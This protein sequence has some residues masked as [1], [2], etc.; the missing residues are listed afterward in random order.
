VLHAT[1]LKHSNPFYAS[2][3]HNELVL[4]VVGAQVCSAVTTLGERP[5]RSWASL[6]AQ[7]M[8]TTGEGEPLSGRSI[9]L[10]GRF[11]FRLKQNK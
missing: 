1:N 9:S 2:N 3:C 6:L 11:G 5:V 10:W 7:G 8:T 4:G